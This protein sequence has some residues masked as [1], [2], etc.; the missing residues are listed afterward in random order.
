ME[1]FK[2]I[3]VVVKGNTDPKNDAA[4]IRGAKLAKRNNAQLTVMDVVAAPESAAK[5][6]K[7]IIDLEELTT[8]LV[9]HREKQ[10]TEAVE[11]LKCDCDVSVKVVVGRDFIEIVRQMVFEKHDL[12]L[13]VA[14]EHLESFDSSDFHI[15]RK[16]PKPVWLLQSEESS[17]CRRVLAAIDLNLESADE[18]RALNKFIMDM[19]TSLSQWENSETH[20]LS[21]WSLYG[22]DALRH[23]GFLKVSEEKLD[24]LLSQEEQKNKSQLKELSARYKNYAIKQH[25]IKGNPVE[26]IP[27]FVYRNNIDVVVM[28]TVG[29]SGIP[30]FLIGNTAETILQK[31]NSS[32]ITLKPDGF[33]SPIR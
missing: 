30:G 11:P 24:N 26:C 21:C 13:K 6:Y 25:L 7:G 3:L 20:V 9:A 17:Q 16:C 10:L 2:N 22:E 27:E 14:N 8:M 18:G 12:L 15:M 29:R 31:I 32:V 23:S 1:R 19:A 33:E 4:L 28:G 5:E